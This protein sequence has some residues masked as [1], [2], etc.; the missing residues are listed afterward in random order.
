[1]FL[2]GISILIIF[3]I[4]ASIMEWQY[5]F[6]SEMGTFYRGVFVGSIIPCLILVFTGL[7][8]Y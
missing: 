7:K 3:A 6:N 5:G 4:I 1:M 2:T 8:N